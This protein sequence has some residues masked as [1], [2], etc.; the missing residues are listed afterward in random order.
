MSFE[1]AEAPKEE[2][3]VADEEP[4]RVSHEEAPWAEASADL[5]EGFVV[6][7]DEIGADEGHRVAVVYENERYSALTGVW[8]SNALLPTDRRA[9]STASGK[10]NWRD[11]TEVEQSRLGKFWKWDGEW[12]CGRFE[13]ASGFTR[14][15][16]EEGRSEPTRLDFVR[17]RRLERSA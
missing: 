9:Y 10:R 4:E 17:R 13:Y 11:R 2:K 7:E 3:A 14:R 12:Y 15:A 5:P 8:S 6:E 16:F 1:E